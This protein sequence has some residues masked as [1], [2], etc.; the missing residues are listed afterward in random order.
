MTGDLMRIA[1]PDPKNRQ[2]NTAGFIDHIGGILEK[3]M[4]SRKPASL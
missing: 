3:K 4:S 2:V 1:D